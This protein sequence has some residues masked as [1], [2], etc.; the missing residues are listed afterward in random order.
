MRIVS[1]VFL[2]FCIL[3][4]MSCQKDPQ[5][6]A[7][8]DLIE[9]ITPGYSQQ[10]SLELIEPENGNDVY[11]VAGEN[12]KVVLRGNNTVSLATAYNQY[13]KYHCNAHVSWFGD[14]LNLP[15]TLP[16]PA[17]TTHRI[18]NGKYRVYFNYCTL[19]Y[20]G[21]W[22]DWE[23][24]QREI[25]YMAMNS[26]NTPLSVVGL[27]GVWY[28]TLLRFGFTDEEARSYL[29]DPA[30]F[31]W[32][33]MPNIESFGGP[34]PKS[35]IDS[36][37]ALGKQVVNRQ[38]ELGM[39]P[40]QQGFSGA[41]PRKMMEKF[42]EAKI[43]KQPDW[44]GFEGICQLDPLDP[45]F[46]ELGKTFLEEEQKLYGTYGLYAA[47]P[48]HESKPPVDTPEYLNAVGSSIRKLMKT[49][50]PD[51]LW[52]MQAWSFRKDIA[53]VVPKHDLLVLSLNGALGGEDHFCNHDFVV[54]N[55]HN[56]GG[57]VNLHGDLP[58]V[59]SNQFM[60]AKQKTPNVVG[61]G[62][63]ME[64]IG[65]NPVFYELAFEMPVHQDSVK[66]EEWLNKYAE[67]RYGAFSDAANKAWELL[68]AGPYRAGTNGVE[69]SSIICARPA[70]DV[71]KSG[72]NAG[73]NIPYDP[74][75][76]IEAEVCLLQDA[77]QLK[78]SGPYR[79]DIVDVQRQIMSNLGQEIHKK[80]AEAFKKKDKEAFAL[81]SGRF[82]ELLKD[83][84]I[85]LRTRTEF[86]FDQ[87]LTDA[88][89][90]GT[91]DEER[92]LFEKNASSLVTI[93]GGQVDVRQFD[94]SWREWTG[95]IEGYYLQRW[96]QFYDMLQGHLDN[97][98][99]YR[100]EDAKMDLGR[101]A[102]RAN[103]FYDSLADWEL[104]FVDRPGK[105]RTPVTEGDE[106]AVARRMLDKYKQ[107]L[108]EY[109]NVEK[110]N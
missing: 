73:F 58:L 11:E 59:S 80:A 25:D 40:I 81:H 82:L 104:A 57:R 68:L 49:F 86:N 100:E 65:Q 16:V 2:L 101:Q 20:T 54:G 89:A 53:S 78:G 79:F 103:E 87:W 32:Q 76:L 62:L 7:A 52:V 110:T 34:L 10:F 64:S 13:L 3:S 26:I 105:V 18:I 75:S 70:V 69:S 106:V 85:L 107:L 95:L 93:W 28:N 43:Q 60:K 97:G 37:I 83:V 35:W 99:I 46:T 90:W 31:A 15:A 61:S 22:W 44:Y 50:D 1:K 6:Q 94:Y 19:S 84:D 91:T 23:R 41:V 51:A 98:T 14:Q 4:L 56:F 8:Y 21:A 39:T 63:F 30:H 33:W 55:L 109:Y 74:Q 42:P 72:P 66:L 27:E 108:K 92:N 67:R 9:R 71:K 47:D 96:K 88:R 77:E 29:V 102:F 36:H 45:L 17:E 38:L 12:G 5:I 48:F 24:W